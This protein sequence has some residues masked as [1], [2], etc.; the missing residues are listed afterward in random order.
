MARWGLR[1]R[2]E[3]LEQLILASNLFYQK[4]GVGRIDKAATPIKVVEVVDG[5]KITEAYFEKKSTVDFYGI[6]QGHFIAFDAKQ[7]AT[8]S[9]PLKNIHEHQIAYMAEV[10]QQGGVSFLIVEFS[11]LGRYF[12]LPFEVL[13]DYHARSKRG[14]R[15]SIP[16]EAFPAE[17]EIELFRGHRLK[18]LESLNRYFEWKEE[19]SSI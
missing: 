5:T 8:G 19:Y 1:G 3:E 6:V 16:L 2:G 14:G 7:V 9:L 15:K 17:L 10:E 18:Y 13:A 4:H 12:L 11:E